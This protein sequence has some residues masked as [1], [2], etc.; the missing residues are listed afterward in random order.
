MQFIFTGHTHMQNIAVKTT[1]KG[2]TIYDINTSALIGYA[3]AI[4]TVAVYD[5]RMESQATTSITSTGICT[6]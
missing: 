2:N 5:D 6:A 1:E 4:R 3:S